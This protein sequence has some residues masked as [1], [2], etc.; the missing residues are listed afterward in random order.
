MTRPNSIG[1]SGYPRSNSE[2]SR[3]KPPIAT[4]PVSIRK[5]APGSSI[6]GTVL[7]NAQPMPSS[8]PDK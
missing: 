1:A 2:S 8:N 3:L 4:I 5:R 7:M 6:R